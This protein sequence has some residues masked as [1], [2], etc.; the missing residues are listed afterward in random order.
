MRNIIIILA[1]IALAGGCF[2][3]CN[4]KPKSYRFVK[5]LIDGKETEDQFTAKND[6]D[7]LNQ[8]FDRMQK[9]IVE[10]IDKAQAPYKSMYVISPEG[11]TLNTNEELLRAVMESMPQMPAMPQPGAMQPA[12]TQKMVPLDKTPR[13]GK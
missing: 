9:V 12:T 3:S 1:I 10:N 7:A 6:T 5:V 8:Y 2:T 4:E 11:D 13:P